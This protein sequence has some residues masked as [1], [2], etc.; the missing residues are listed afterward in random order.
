MAK[1]KTKEFSKYTYADTKE[2][3][4]TLWVDTSEYTIR[5]R[6]P[7]D[8]WDAGDYGEELVNFGVCIGAQNKNSYLSRDRS[9]NKEHIGFFPKAG[10][11][12]FM[13]IESYGTGSTF[14]STNPCYQP[15]KIFKTHQGAT[16]WLKTPE[17]EA[18]KDSDYFGGHNDYLIESVVV[19]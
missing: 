7:D 4:V 16:Q 11:T 6:D 14:G 3:Y 8:E 13:V 9:L 10:D 2:P 17:A 5:E 15:V 12:V 1:K 18:C 19:K